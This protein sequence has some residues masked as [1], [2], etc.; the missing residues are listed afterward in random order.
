MKA[1][2]HIIIFALFVALSVQAKEPIDALIDSLSIVNTHQEKAELSARIAKQLKDTDWDRSV[3]YLNIS[4]EEALK[5]KNNDKL[6]AE[7]YTNA[8]AIYSSK[9]VLDVTL[10][11][12]L[13]AYE[14]YKKLNDKDQ[15]S[16][17]ENNF[18]IVYARLNN[19]EKALFYFN[20][21]YNYQL[22]KNDSLRI[23]Q[24]LNNMGTICLKNSPDS[25][26]Y[27]YR[28]GLKFA[29]TINNSI[30]NTYLTTNIARAWNDIPN[31]DSATF[32]FY[33]AIDLASE[34][35]NNS[36]KSFVY[37][38]YSNFCLE[39]KNYSNAIEYALKTRK[40][41]ESNKYSFA[42]KSAVE[43]LYKAYIN[44]G[45]YKSATEY[46]EEYNEIRDSLNVEE[47]A[48]NVERLRLQQEFKSQAKIQELEADKK[49]IKNVLIV[50][51]LVVII[52]VLLLV[53]IRYKNR[54]AK[55][56]LTQALLEAREQELQNNLESKN[57]VLIA[58]AMTEMHRTDI[59]NN[60]LED[61]RTIK[62]K[63]VKKETQSAIDIILQ[64]LQRDL[65]TDTW[66]EFEVSF[67]NVH[68]SF[69]NNLQLNHPDLTPKDKRL[70]ALLYMNLS[71]KE[72]S[73]IT[74]QSFKS[75]ENARVR[76]RKKLDITNTNSGL[77]EY[78]NSL[79]HE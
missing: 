76:L 28:S 31:S 54:I 15:Q 64:R 77:S 49:Q 4:I 60:I 73:Q 66:Q 25:A 43:T 11:Y 26:L 6:L 34:L 59:I 8:S 30:L 71:S 29:N 14:L 67:E 45:N 27:Y 47:K 16:I 61:L 17:I 19:P 35:S 7:V 68:Q 74:G 20:K 56:K 51:C 32:Y 65:N 57:K 10:E 36:V 53:L 52:L 44:E 48:V 63:A 13:K 5:S 69:Y 2:I 42:Q 1:F 21:V 39:N 72:I 24:I 78:L 58:K 55:S 3:N 33:R 70:C 37:D 79:N 38:A 9:E 23:A 46:F 62:F 40:L 22:E 12:Y 18:A 41:N 50:S 75:V